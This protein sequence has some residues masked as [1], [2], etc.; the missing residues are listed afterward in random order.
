MQLWS[1]DGFF[2]SSKSEETLALGIAGCT[3]GIM[4]GLGFGL[5]G[6]TTLA[7]GLPRLDYI[8]NTPAMRDVVNG[9]RS[10]RS[11][12]SLHGN[13]RS[14]IYGGNVTGAGPVPPQLGCAKL[15]EDYK[16]VFDKGANDAAEFWEDADNKPM[17]T[18]MCI[19]MTYPVVSTCATH[20]HLQ[21]DDNAVD[22]TGDV[23]TEGK[24][25][26]FMAFAG[27]GGAGAA[28]KIVDIVQVTEDDKTQSLKELRE[29]K[30]FIPCEQRTR[31]ECEE[32]GTWT[33]FNVEGTQA[34][35][36]A[37]MC[38][39]TSV[40]PTGLQTT[41]GAETRNI[42]KVASVAYAVDKTDLEV[43]EAIC[44]YA[45]TITTGDK[46]GDPERDGTNSNGSPSCK[47]LYSLKRFGHGE[48]FEGDHSG[49]TYDANFQPYN[50]ASD[51]AASRPNYKDETDFAA[52]V[53]LPADNTDGQGGEFWLRVAEQD[54]YVREAFEGLGKH[55][56][57]K[58][59]LEFVSAFAASAFARKLSNENRYNQQDD[60]EHYHSDPDRRGRRSNVDL[61]TPLSDT[62]KEN[63]AAL[64]DAL[65]GTCFS[66]GLTNG[67][68]YQSGWG[69][70]YFSFAI[71]LVVSHLVWFGS[72]IA[73]ADMES[74]RF[75]ARRAMSFFGILVGFTGLY[76]L[77]F[78]YGSGQ[79]AI[80]NDD[81]I[82]RW[83][84]MLATNQN[85]HDQAMATGFINRLNHGRLDVFDSGS[86]TNTATIQALEGLHFVILAFAIVTP[87][88]GSGYH[89]GSGSGTKESGWLAN[90]F[91]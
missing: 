2:G 13:T 26:G 75:N 23:T 12:N 71:I 73:G 50:P 21:V 69:A 6:D 84:N 48:G 52:D 17:E 56:L 24:Y 10:R 60:T 14:Q 79:G 70:A 61:D 16:K 3:P 83:A 15:L 65:P 81:E 30:D 54:M 45:G 57:M 44:R 42:Y 43:D 22:A 47:Y 36:A 46:N 78:I 39:A 8:E 11:V 77:F 62:Q 86:F 35:P 5:Y 67:L 85:E 76:I 87:L 41:E 7:P 66:P 37:P 64:L 33:G 27:I 68:L 34:S 49:Y 80:M 31:K 55:Q 38:V 9:G 28:D 59:D 20:P 19:A 58:A 72:A 29:S 88:Y 63:R 25:R 40:I 4:A 74:T 1:L 91:A 51:F 89:D 18:M 90:S 53:T 82:R 32:S